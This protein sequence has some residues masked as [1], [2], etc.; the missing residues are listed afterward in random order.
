[1]I[2]LWNKDYFQI[3]MFDNPNIQEEDFPALLLPD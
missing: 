1:M 3:K 2:P